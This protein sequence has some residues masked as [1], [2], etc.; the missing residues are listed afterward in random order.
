MNKRNAKKSADPE[1]LARIQELIRFK[2][3][4]YN[5]SRSPTSSKM[6]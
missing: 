3:S 6:R 4:G 2:G 1:L 5:E